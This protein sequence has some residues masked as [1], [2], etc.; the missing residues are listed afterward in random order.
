ME[1]S[2]EVLCMPNQQRSKAP[3]E[4]P[5]YTTASFPDTNSLGFRKSW[6]SLFATVEESP[7][8]GQVAHQST[9]LFYPIT[10]SVQVFMISFLKTTLLR[11]NLYAI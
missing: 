2:F 11:Y 4:D 7:S 9:P 5:S 8:V 6:E 3:G 1:N 10:V